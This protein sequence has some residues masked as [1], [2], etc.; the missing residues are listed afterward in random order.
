MVNLR[1]M[2]TNWL[3]ENK[4]PGFS[5]RSVR[6]IFATVKQDGKEAVRNDIT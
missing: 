1:K 4:L 5:E 3:P 6:G 2:N